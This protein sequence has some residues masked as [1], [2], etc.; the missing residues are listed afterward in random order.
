AV[1]A[2][3]HGGTARRGGA[4][5]RPGGLWPARAPGLRRAAG[6]LDRAAAELSRAS[7]GRRRT[8][9]PPYRSAFDRA[10]LGDLERRL[11]P[12]RAGA[13]L[14]A[15][16]EHA[17]IAREHLALALGGHRAEVARIQREL[18]HPALARGQV[19]ALEA[20]QRDP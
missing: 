2:E 3:L 4:D 9:A 14:A 17:V 7:G 5:R 12:G 15:A 8:A 1:G 18:Q 19:H 13:R 20:A 11:A 10:C 6:P 16:D